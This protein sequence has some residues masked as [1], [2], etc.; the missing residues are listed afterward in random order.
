MRRGLRQIK[1]PFTTVFKDM[2]HCASLK[3][4]WQLSG[5]RFQPRQRVLTDDELCGRQTPP[6]F[7]AIR[8]TRAGRRRVHQRQSASGEERR[9]EADAKWKPRAR[10][11]RG[12][13][14]LCAPCVEG[15]TPTAEIVL[16]RRGRQC[17]LSATVQCKTH[18]D[19]RPSE[20]SEHLCIS[21]IG[22]AEFPS[23]SALGIGSPDPQSRASLLEARR[24]RPTPSF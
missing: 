9:P 7:A 18:W 24:S 15:T 4:K 21:A 10:L 3:A 1:Y 19:G 2:S 14:A 8:N 12:W 20:P 17:D 22:S 11:H 16:Q 23:R 6:I 13:S 5:A